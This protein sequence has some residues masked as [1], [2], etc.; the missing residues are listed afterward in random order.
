MGVV[1]IDGRRYC[2]ATCFW[3]QGRVGGEGQCTI[4]PSPSTVN[5][6]A[7]DWDSL[8]E[9]HDFPDNPEARELAVKHYQ[10]VQWLRKRK[11]LRTTVINQHY[12]NYPVS[13]YEIIGENV[14][15]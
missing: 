11:A 12:T 10:K 14:D 13:A 2:C 5:C 1:L 8:C 4:P 7:Q 9:Q 15:L 6:G 3:W